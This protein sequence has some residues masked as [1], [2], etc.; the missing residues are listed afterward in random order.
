MSNYIENNLIDIKRMLDIVL[1]YKENVLSEQ[2]FKSFEY[3]PNDLKGFKLALLSTL[4]TENFDDISENVDEDLKKIILNNVR[5]RR[6]ETIFSFENGD[7]FKIGSGINIKNLPPS[8]QRDDYTRILRMI[9]N[10]IAHSKYTYE[11][12][13]VNIS[14]FN[15]QFEVYCDVDWLEMMVLCLFANRQSTTKEGARDIQLDLFDLGKGSWYDFSTVIG[16]ITTIENGSDDSTLLYHKI[17]AKNYRTM[18]LIEDGIGAFNADYENFIKNLYKEF[19]INV[20][21]IEKIDDIKRKVLGIQNEERY[22]EMT[23]EKKH[24]FFGSR[25]YAHYDEERKN[26]LA[27]KHI[28]NLLGILKGSIDKQYKKIC[29]VGTDFVIDFAGEYCFKCYVNLVYNYI[30]EKIDFEI[31]N[32]DETK[33]NIVIR[34][35][36]TLEAHIRNACCHNRIKI[37]GEE[38]YLFD[39]KNGV[40]NFELKCKMNDFI[41]LTN[42]LIDKLSKQGFIN[43][44]INDLFINKKK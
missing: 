21:K 26:T 23:I 38:V 34:D 19:D 11:N 29:K 28:I 8:F 14:A 16:Y 40:I 3:R 25:I 27:Y 44:N 24:A 22:N 36:R 41:E 35:D 15:G 31:G 42:D 2:K 32:I 30:N 4:F 10:G 20:I 5:I 9:R 1:T 43:I 13:V 39:E 18:Q 7:F 6:R 33:F 12:G 17:A 37:N